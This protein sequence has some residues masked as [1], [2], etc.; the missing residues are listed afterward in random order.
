MAGAQHRPV[1]GP[2]GSCVLH[3]GVEVL[4]IDANGKEC[5]P[6]PTAHPRGRGGLHGRRGAASAVVGEFGR[7]VI[8]IG[9]DRE[10]S[11][12][13]AFGLRSP[14]VPN[15]WAKAITESQGK[16]LEQVGVAYVVRDRK[17]VV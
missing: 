11:V 13:T 4:G 1:G 8:A 15:I 14:G 16:T 12:L 9:T 10:A 7:A 6:S 17:S 2:S 5:R 3:A